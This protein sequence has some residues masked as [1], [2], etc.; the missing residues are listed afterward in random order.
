MTTETIIFAIVALLLAGWLAYFEYRLRK[1]FRGK[2]G[3]DMEDALRLI[4]DEL[5]KLH[6]SK[7]DHAKALAHIETR[8]S[9]S[10]RGVGT[11]RFNPFRDVGGNQ[12][13]ATAFLNERGDGVVISALYGRDHTNVY[14]K[15]ITAYVSE[16]ELTPEEEAALT[17][18]RPK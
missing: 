18:A 1:I 14:A 3:M 11:V 4:A 10:I 16:F 9:G 12:S 15:P 13:F 17:A 7:E 8:L 2:S 5:D 6:G